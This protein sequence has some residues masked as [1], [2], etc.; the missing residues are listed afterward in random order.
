MI[1]TLAFFL[2]AAAAIPHHADAQVIPLPIRNV[3]SYFIGNAQSTIQV[4]IIVDPFCS[5]CHEEYLMWKGLKAQLT[6]DDNDVGVQFII[7]AEPFHPWSFTAAIGWMTCRQHNASALWPFAE[8]MWD[9]Y[10][11]FGLGDWGSPN[12]TPENLTEALVIDKMAGFAAANAGVP[13]TVFYHGMTNRSVSGAIVNPWAVA[14]E[15]WKVAVTRGAASVPW[16][17]VNGVPFYVASNG[18]HLGAAAWTALLNKL[19]AA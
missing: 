10:K 14:R 7:H 9:N 8:A 17:F 4:E 5:D 16:Y 11:D 2:L 3:G 19:L 1:A 15:S 18:G 12:Y 13:R 6:P